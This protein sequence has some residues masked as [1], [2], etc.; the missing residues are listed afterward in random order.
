MIE[1]NLRGTGCCLCV[2]TEIFYHTQ[3]YTQVYSIYI[4]IYIQTMAGKCRV[5]FFIRPHK[6][7]WKGGELLVC[8]ILSVVRCFVYMA[9]GVIMFVLCPIP[10]IT[11]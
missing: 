8:F 9:G 10:F 4:Y 7:R 1:A 6:E 11:I 3:V 2:V 5:V